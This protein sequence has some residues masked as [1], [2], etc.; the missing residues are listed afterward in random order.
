[1]MGSPYLMA[2]GLGIPVE[3]AVTSFSVLEPGEYYIFVRTRN[4]ATG[5]GLD[6]SKDFEHIRDYGLL[7][8]FSNWSYI[9]NHSKAKEKFA[10][11]QLK[12]VAHIAGKRES[13]RLEG[14][15]ISISNW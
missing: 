3:D 6:M 5:M 4:W 7:V 15:S 11:E 8:V 14:L 10:N 13:R 2:H 9:K 1:V 12:W